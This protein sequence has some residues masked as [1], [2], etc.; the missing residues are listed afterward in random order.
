[1]KNAIL[2]HGRKTFDGRMVHCPD[3]IAAA[4]VVHK[5][6]KSQGEE[7]VWVKPFD[8]GDRNQGFVPNIDG[9]ERLF[10]VDFVLTRAT[11]DLW[12]RA[13]VK[14]EVVDHHENNLAI[15]GLQISDVIELVT[16]NLTI[17]YSAVECGAT[18]AWKRYFPESEPPAFL[19]YVRDHDIWKKKLVFTDEI[20]EVIAHKRY[21]A[22]KDLKEGKEE[23]VFSYFDELAEWDM[24]KIKL[25]MPLEGARLLQIKQEKTEMAVARSTP[26]AYGPATMEDGSI[27]E[28]VPG[29]L[30]ALNPDGSEDRLVSDIGHLLL[31]KY[32]DIKFAAMNTAGGRWELRSERGGGFKCVEIA[33][34]YG[35]GGHP[36][37]CGCQQEIQWLDAD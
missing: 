30:V 3:G 37:A 36:H 6:L 8:H 32:P 16:G 22:T 5:W 2:F 26:C 33:L 10:V 1:M 15:L 14:I 35:G 9:V 34:A 24:D 4:W 25:L 21:L 23:A 13:G 11:L 7:I 27:A 19:A 20:Y 31:Q 17:E 29:R 28:S 12:E 18:L